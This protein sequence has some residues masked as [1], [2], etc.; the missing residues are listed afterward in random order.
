M[1]KILL[2]P[3]CR[4]EGIEINYWTNS[5]AL[6]QANIIVF[7]V[8][9]LYLCTHTLRLLNIYFL[10][11][12]N[13]RLK[14]SIFIVY[15]ASN[16]PQIVFKCHHHMWSGIWYCCIISIKIIHSFNFF[17]LSLTTGPYVL[18]TSHQEIFSSWMP[19]QSQ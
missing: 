12:W 1:D 4:Y 13:L 3:S 10:I 5:K 16:L 9:E 18:T 8:S 19:M 14:K 11:I 17:L 7:S 2:D 15:L 6:V